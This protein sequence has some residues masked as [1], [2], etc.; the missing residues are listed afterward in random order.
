MEVRIDETGGDCAA[1]KPNQMG[2][3]SDRRLKIGETAVR[4]YSA[5]RQG[6]R[7]AF[8]VTENLAFVEDQI[9]FFHHARR[10]RLELDNRPATQSE[11]GKGLTSLSFIGASQHST[12]PSPARL[13]ST[14]VPHLSQTYRLPRAFAI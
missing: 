2:S 6:H 8:R 5:G 4:G 7:I 13:H 14:S 3:R 1:G 12:E 11:D 10:N 9:R